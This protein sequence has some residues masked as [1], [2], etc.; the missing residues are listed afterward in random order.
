MALSDTKIRAAKG[1]AKLYK[2]SDGK[3]LQLWVYPDGARRW[4]G[5]YRFAG[6]QRT[7]AIG[8]YPDTSAKDAR[9]A[10]DEA[11]RVLSAG[12]DPMV[13]RRSE[14]SAKS[15]AAGNTFDVIADEL[16][17]LKRKNG[18]D[19]TT[20]EKA[21]W[22]LGLARP[23]LGK[24]PIETIMAADVLAVVRAVEARGRNETARR[25]RATIGQ[26]FRLA[27]STGRATGDPTPALKGALAT[28]RTEHHAA[29]TEPGR[30]GELLRSI[31]GY[32]GAPETRIA[33]QIL[34][35]TFVRSTE[36]R[37]AAWR[38]FDLDAAVWTIPA[39]RMKR[40]RAREAV[41]HGVPL[42]PQTV[43][44]LRELHT[45]T[46]RGKLLFPSVRSTT[47]PISEGT[48]IAALRRLGWSKDEMTPHGFRSA[49]SSML[50]E[51]GLFNPDAIER[52]LSHIEKNAVRRA[53]ERAKYWDER[54]RMMAWWADRID[55]M[56]AGDAAAVS[57]VVRMAS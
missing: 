8:V 49:A 32:A 7:L 27:I 54:V 36:L 26:V 16:I 39:I 43:A 52:Q 11:R 24:R 17:E 15:T 3:G 29:I 33:L 14:R 23:M 55:A 38:E 4:R 22:L 30:F 19:G 34:A 31:D 35:L 40:V 5:A 18:L 37:A 44:L 12:D 57:N 20:I 10:W 2:L 46:G 53:Y 56:R 45:I 42:A 28:V 9:T 47:R 13:V 51:S 1:K 48:M 6:S 21:T 50:N 41:D 25:L